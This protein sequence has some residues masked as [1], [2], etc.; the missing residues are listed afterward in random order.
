MGVSIAGGAP[1]L[2]APHFGAKGGLQRRPRPLCRNAYNVFGPMLK[3]YE[4]KHRPKH[5][6]AR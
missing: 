5:K 4:P 3:F 2:P 1:F 6:K